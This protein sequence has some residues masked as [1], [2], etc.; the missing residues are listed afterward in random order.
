VRAAISGVV[1]VAVIVACGGAGG[2]EVVNVPTN[3]A[4]ASS[5]SSSATD[6]QTRPPS[7]TCA[8]S[9]VAVGQICPQRDIPPSNASS[10][11]GCKS[12][13]DC[14]TGLNGRCMGLGGRSRVTRDAR[15]LLGAPPPPPPR[16]RCEYDGCVTDKDCGSKMRCVCGA[17]EY[18]NRCEPIDTCLTDKECGVDHQ[19]QCGR[20]NG[21][22]NYCV[23]GDCRSA[24]DC[25]NGAACGNGTGPG[26]CHGLRDKCSKNEDCSTV[27]EGAAYCGYAMAQHRWQCRVVLPVPPG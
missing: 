26:F 18:R 5:S 2:G 7:G 16:S 1:A 3:V 17:D 23:E 15:D 10:P 25:A 14:K 19:C 11:E 27:P 4:T 8:R 9:S 13:A 22:A 21:L 6:E 20:V 24:A 12:D